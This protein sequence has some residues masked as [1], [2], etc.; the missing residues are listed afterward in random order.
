MRVDA[1]YFDGETARDNVVTVRLIDKSLEFTGDQTPLTKWTIAGLHP[2]D[3][4]SPGQPFRITHDQKPGAR[5]IIKDQ[6]FI[7]DLVRL[8]SHLKGGY[9][10]RHVGQVLG[11]TAAGLAA[12][13]ILGYISMTVLP[14]H[15][16]KILPSD[17]K[18]TW[19]KQVVSSVVGTS[20]RCETPD[21]KAAVSAMV[22]ALAE[23]GSELP[24]VSVE[25]YDMDLVNAF[26]V[27]G[28]RVILTRGL[29][30]KAS[31]PAEV[32]GVLAHE[33]GHVFHLH[34]EAQFV[35]VSGLQVL[36][37]LVSGGTSTDLVTTAAGLAAILRYS[38]E[39]EK[40]A[41][42]FARSVMETASV[43][44]MGLKSFFEK[45]MKLEGGGVKDSDGTA[46]TLD[47]IGNVFST[48]P[49][50]ED[51]IKEIKPLPAGKSPVQIMTDAQ[52]QAL[53]KACS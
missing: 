21:S 39:A 18:N 10:F 53:R 16:V 52:W 33:L 35:R 50:T 15:V 20:R 46:S 30:N 3:P 2:I 34:A 8:N 7:D 11:W 41:D 25:V 47:R 9:S 12:L 28:G 19:G 31:T 1:V 37:S 22:A 44:P 24:P 5:L 17:M 26:A 29:I 42:E 43:D 4:P 14:Q 6:T 48:H 51:R 27:P 40:E 23:G 36:V 45:L 38:R 13:G 49:G 32:T